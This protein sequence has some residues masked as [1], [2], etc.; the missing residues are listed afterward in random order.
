M[1]CSIWILLK[2]L[3]LSLY[4][5]RIQDHIWEC[6]NYNLQGKDDKIHALLP[7]DSLGIFIKKSEQQ[8]EQELYLLHIRGLA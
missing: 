8:Q 6:P 1:F 7:V 2:Q 5:V 3:N 4:Q